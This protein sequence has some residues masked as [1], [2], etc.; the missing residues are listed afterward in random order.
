[1]K[2]NKDVIKQIFK[3][4]KKYDPQTFIEDC[5]YKLIKELF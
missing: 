4:V 2:S 1:M 3:S 5:K